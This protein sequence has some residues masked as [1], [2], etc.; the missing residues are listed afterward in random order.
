MK[1]IN[2]KCN[3]EID[4]L[5]MTDDGYCDDCYDAILDNLLINKVGE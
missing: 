5:H 3:N 2:P 1:C 4:A